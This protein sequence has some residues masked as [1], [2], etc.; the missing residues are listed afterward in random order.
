MK[1]GKR[2]ARPR[3]T[4]APLEGNQIR[5][6]HYIDRIF[7]LERRTGI[8]KDRSAIYRYIKIKI[9]EIVDP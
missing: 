3:F 1:T 4:I 5:L 9:N 7:P 2:D 8:A 6:F